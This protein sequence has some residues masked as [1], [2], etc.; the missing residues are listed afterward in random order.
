MFSSSTALSAQAPPHV[1]S[2]LDSVAEEDDEI[3]TEGVAASSSVANANDAHQLLEQK[4][5]EVAHM[6]KS[7]ILSL[8]FPDDF[9]D[10]FL[11]LLLCVVFFIH[12]RCHTSSCLL[13]FLLF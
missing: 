2:Q 10:V 8:P 12:F 7:V 13:F 9:F 11:A 4:S 1:I 5:A 6:E 3:A